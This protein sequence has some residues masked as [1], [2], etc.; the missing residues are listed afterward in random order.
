M[1]RFCQG[2]GGRGSPAASPTLTKLAIFMLFTLRAKAGYT[3]GPVASSFRGPFSAFGG[4][5]H[6]S[7]V[8]WQCP[9]TSPATS[10][11][12]NLCLQPGLEPRTLGATSRG[13][14][15]GSQWQ[16][17]LWNSRRTSDSLVSLVVLVSVKRRKSCDS[18]LHDEELD[19]PLA[20]ATKQHIICSAEIG[21]VAHFLQMAEE[22]K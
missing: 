7:E 3:S 6:C 18:R 13:R 2:P 22:D 20:S 17:S 10:M 15:S 14:N 9:G 12:S 5:V 11:P 8:P 21:N 16:V 1:R 4:L 19:F